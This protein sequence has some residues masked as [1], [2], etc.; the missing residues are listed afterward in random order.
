MT[1]STLAGI[2]ASLPEKIVDNEFFS[3]YLETSGEWIDSRTGIKTR[4]FAEPGDMVSSLALPAAKSALKSAGVKAQDLDMIL[5]ATTT[6]DRFMPSTACLLQGM[7]GANSCPAMDIQA[8]CSGF[9]YGLEV[10]DALVRSDKAK[11]VLLVG[12]DLYS[13]VLDFQDRSTCILFGDGAGAAV[14]AA[15]DKPGLAAVNLHADGSQ[16]DVITMKGHVSGNKITGEAF[17]RMDGPKVYK[18]AIEAMEKSARE[19]C[20]AA[21]I[22]PAD[23][24][25]LVPHQ[26]NLRIVDTLATRLGVQPDRVVRTVREHAN[27]SAASVPL[28]LETIWASI[29]PGD[30]VLFTA[31]GGGFTWGS[32]LWRA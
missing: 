7:L 12:A 23:V 2:G 13:R 9:V 24:A 11:N 18:L 30:W 8:V 27:T 10:A 17:F 16:A 4:R 21:G 25:W 28:A 6:P 26:A 5:F 22:E 1:Y 29:K 31:A 19:A 15:C 32:A 3:D 14:V 20:E